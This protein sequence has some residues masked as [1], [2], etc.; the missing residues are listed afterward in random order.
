MKKVSIIMIMLMLLGAASL[1][2]AQIVV[3][4]TTAS[5]IRIYEKSEREKGFYVRPEG[6]FGFGFFHHNGMLINL[7]CSFN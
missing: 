2:E 4:Q 5:T 3:S 6:A 7:N 1:A